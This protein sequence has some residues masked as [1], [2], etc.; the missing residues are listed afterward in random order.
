M[1]YVDGSNHRERVYEVILHKSIP[2]QI[3]QFIRILVIIKDMLKD[4]CGN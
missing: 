2:K 4:L 1:A 3:H